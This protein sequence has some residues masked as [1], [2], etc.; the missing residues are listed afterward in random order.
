MPT[1]APRMCAAQA[2]S[3]SLAACACAAAG[4]PAGS[5]ARTSAQHS[6]DVPSTTTLS[7]RNHHRGMWP[8]LQNYKSWLDVDKEV[9]DLINPIKLAH[10]NV[11]SNINS[12]HFKTTYKKII[13]LQLHLGK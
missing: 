7:G 12:L 11:N 2:T 4:A 1:L 3:W 13:S 10:K 5:G 9:F 8:N 6:S